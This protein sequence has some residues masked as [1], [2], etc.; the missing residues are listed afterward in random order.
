LVKRRVWI[1]SAFAAS[2]VAASLVARPAG[3]SFPGHNGSIAF[4]GPCGNGSCIKVTAVGSTTEKAMP[5]TSGGDHAHYSPNGKVLVF[6]RT[7]KSGC[8][9]IYTIHIN[10]THLRRLTHGNDDE[11]PAWSPDGKQI[12]FSRQPI[13][14]N[15]QLFVVNADGTHLHKLIKG[16]VAGSEPDWSVKGLIAFQGS[17]NDIYVVTSKGRYVKNLTKGTPAGVG[18]PNWSPDGKWITFVGGT[19]VWR[20]TAGGT[21]ETNL[22]NTS[23]LKDH[24]AFSPDGKLIVYQDYVTGSSELWVMKANGSGPTQLTH[25][26]ASDAA[27]SWQP[28]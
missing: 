22:T 4:R 7:G 9:Q 24:P 3:A 14:G 2:V 10:G 12:V 27:P 23:S 21:Q 28:R 18:G 11:D 8:C 1:V 13:S 5:G 16:T 19:D 6:D 17:P 15:G 26:N 25:D 20:M